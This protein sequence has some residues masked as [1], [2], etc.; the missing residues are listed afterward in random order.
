MSSNETTLNEIA[1][2]LDISPTDYQLA[3]ERYG[4]VKNWL[5]EGEYESGCAPDVFLQGSFRL[6][7]VVRPYVKDQ[8]GDFDI[9]QVIELTQPVNKVLPGMLKGDVGDRLRENQNYRRMLDEEGKR[10]WTLLYSSEPGRAG[11][12]LDIL[13]A[14]PSNS[15]VSDQIAITDKRQQGYAW[16]S[17]N[18]QGYYRWFKSQNPIAESLELEQRQMIHGA[19]RSLYTRPSDVPMQLVRTPLQRSLQL[20]KRH[21]DVAFASRDHRPISIILT[22]IAARVTDSSTIVGVLEDFISY[23]T[24]RIEKVVAGHELARDGVLD[25]DGREWCIPNPVDQIYGSSDV[26]NFADKWNKEPQLPV[27]FF[28]WM[29]QLERDL[30]AFLES[31]SS[32]E[33]NLQTKHFGTNE[34][35]PKRIEQKI[36]D[37][38]EMRSETTSGLLD[39]IHLAIDGRV[40]WSTV[41]ELAQKNFDQSKEGTSKEVARINFYQVS[42]HQGRGFADSAEADIRRILSEQSASAAFVLCCNLLL[43]SATHQMVRSAISGDTYP[44]VLR[45][46][47]LRLADSSLGFPETQ[48]RD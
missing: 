20:M 36:R 23:V 2:H 15:P 37:G 4:A 46:P 26:E 1:A 19:N 32:D 31:G 42:R 38:L 21:R 12:H 44:D 9:D 47:I 41:K 34:S 11:F 6:G 10:C 40:L 45:W 35:Y 5:E 22:T 39:L 7:T 16:S 14:I 28:Q 43:G 13:P 27:Q 18:P 3:T 33:L 25:F 29:Y 24:S 48:V 8:D 30:K 17:S